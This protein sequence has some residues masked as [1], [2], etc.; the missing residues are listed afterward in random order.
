MIKGVLF[1][2]D[3][4]LVDNL[5]AHLEAFAAFCRKYEVC[6]W[7]GRISELFGMGN[8]DIMRRLLPEELISERGLQALGDEKEQMYRDIYAPT[9]KPVKGLPELLS[10][11]NEAGVKCAVGSSGCAANV[12][13]VLE[14]CNIEK[15]FT[16]RVNGDMV[17]HCKP[18]PEIYL[19]AAKAIGVEPSECLVFEDSKAGVK[20]GV[21]A[22]MKVV[23]LAT[24]LSREELARDTQAIK[25]I[26]DFTQIDVE[27]IAQL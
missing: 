24:T 11:L 2:M 8:D 23:A 4:V 21:S 3:G 9:I 6:N 16:A 17:T 10:A 15:Y 1:D 18:A 12:A 13:F 19:T 20:A 27:H 22:G 26:D 25:I 7:Q 5:D 14:H